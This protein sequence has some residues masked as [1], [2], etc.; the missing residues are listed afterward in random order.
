MGDNSNVLVE[1]LFF[2]TSTKHK[3]LENNTKYQKRNKM[4]Q[5]NEGDV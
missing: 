3:S 5:T 4:K 2:T 1:N